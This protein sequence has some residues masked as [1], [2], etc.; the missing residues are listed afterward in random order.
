VSL[1]AVLKKIMQPLRYVTPVI[2]VF[3]TD[4]HPEDQN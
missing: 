2:F 4:K 3:D 1:T